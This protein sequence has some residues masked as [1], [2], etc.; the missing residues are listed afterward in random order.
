[1]KYFLYLFLASL[2]LPTSADECLLRDQMLDETAQ[3]VSQV[4]K[5]SICE[6]TSSIKTQAEMEKVLKTM[7]YNQDLDL[8]NVSKDRHKVADHLNDC[9]PEKDS[10]ALVINFA[11]TG[12]FNPKS[13]DIMTE[14]MACFAEK[15]LDEK[16]NKNVFH[17]LATIQK[18]HQPSQYKWA[19]IEAG[20]FNQ[21]F[22]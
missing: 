9:S 18:K 2:S 19:G 21:F 11:G 4:I 17:T 7:F 12:A 5:K 3:T 13:F 16:L 14:F 6:T 15:K 8:A 10:K 22:H 1:M 20:P